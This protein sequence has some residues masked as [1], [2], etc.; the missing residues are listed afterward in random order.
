MTRK[1]LVIY[2]RGNFCPDTRRTREFLA[3]HAVPYRVVDAALDPVAQQRVVQWTG[4]MSFPTLVITDDDGTE[5]LEPPLPLSPGQ[6]P[7]NVDRGTLLT[8]ATVPVLERFLRRN[9]FLP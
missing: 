7:R 3:E 2:V 9:G 4:Y 6:S 8:E 5:P 1:Q